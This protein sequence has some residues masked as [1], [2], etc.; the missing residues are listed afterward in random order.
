MKYLFNGIEAV[1]PVIE[2]GPCR[3]LMRGTGTLEV[4]VQAHMG[5]TIMDVLLG[6]MNYE[7][8]WEDSDV[9]AFVADN[10]PLFEVN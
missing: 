6:N 9:A 3:D 10:L 5:E 7:T 2:I 4:H 1:N 8:T